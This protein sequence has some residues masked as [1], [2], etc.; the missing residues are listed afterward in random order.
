[1]IFT[2]GNQTVDLFDRYVPKKVILSL[3]GGLDSASLFYL[4]CKYYPEMEVI[5]FT[6]KDL[7]APF[8]ALCALDI[9]QFMKDNFPN[10][11]IGEHYMH[12]FDVHDPELRKN[13]EEQWD[14]ERVMVNGELVGRCNTV[15]GLVKILEKRK[16]LEACYK[17][18]NGTL[19]VTG[20]TK[21][22]SNDVMQKLGFEELAEERRSY[23]KTSVWGQGYQPYL[24]VD[25]KFVAGIYK[26]HGL[27]NT[28][29]PITGSCVG[30]A[31]E[32]DHFT[33]ECHQCF[34]CH[35]K[36]W[37]FDLTWD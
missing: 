24:N 28:L 30:N 20:M 12:E 18:H 31:N 37:A 14:N 7:H 16:H 13:A 17:L 11:P 26:E 34:W 32:T 25:K 15:S 33:R 2:Y 8:D 10:H 19:I 21:N 35:E 23:D 9:V 29:F 1:M 5:P 27:M 6:G 36:K 4:I 3:S 22:P